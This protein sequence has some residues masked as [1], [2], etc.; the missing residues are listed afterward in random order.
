MQTI[1]LKNVEKL[2]NIPWPKID[3]RKATLKVQFHYVCN[4]PALFRHLG[5]HDSITE[6]HAKKLDE[7]EELS[8]EYLTAANLEAD[9][10]SILANQPE[11]VKIPLDKI[12]NLLSEYYQIFTAKTPKGRYCRKILRKV[13][14]TLEIDATWDI[15]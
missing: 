15:A 14:E 1:E 5:K 6:M 12:P 4:M 8:D 13:A 10:D 2:H 9:L 3:G 7:L 11:K